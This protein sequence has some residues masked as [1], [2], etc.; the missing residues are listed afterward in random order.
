MS[1]DELVESIRSGPSGRT[2]G[3]VF[4][5]R[6]LVDRAD[7]APTEA[8][9]DDFKTLAGS[10]EDMVRTACQRRFNENLAGDLFHGA[11][12]LVRAHIN[13]GHTVVL[14]ASE[15]RFDVEPMARE[16]GVQHL[17]CTELQ[18]EHGSLTG[19]PTGRPLV[20]LAK[21]AAL[22]EFAAREGID[23]GQSHA[24][25]HSEE[26]ISLL[27]SVGFAHPVNPTSTLARQGNQTGWS[28]VE[29]KGRKDSRNPLPIVRTAA[30]YGSLVAAAGAGFV[31]GVGSR[32][33]RRGVDVATW[34]FGR[35]G[36]SLGNISV[37]LVGADNLWSQRPAVFFANHQSTLIDVLVT[38]RIL[39]RGFTIVA[40]AEVRKMPVIGTLFDL[41]DVAFVDRGNTASAIS[42]LQPA[43]DKLRSGTSIAMS[44]EGTRSLT[45]TIGAFKKGGFHL[46]RDAGVPIV[47]I[48]IRNA[49]EIM[50]R[51]ARIAQSGTVE[52]AVHEPVPTAG[53]TREDIEPWRNRIHQLYIDTL[54]DWPGIQAGQRWSKAIANA[55]PK[56]R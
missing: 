50:W 27:E 18:I 49:G 44:P 9:A 47:P 4:D 53:W 2:I 51:N 8:S 48:V 33:R 7:R 42:A 14:A 11:W 45:P 17:L 36:T 5:Y 35:V 25:A 28:A 38:A 40:K 23:L 22:R 56:A 30:M 19:R 6:A 20:G 34:L 15:P 10:T 31:T 21:S 12:R 1:L 13:Q 41:A 32:D 29:F 24:Y 46:A 26:D 54:D 16:L 55:A 43:I 37:D 52:V 3:A 39:Q